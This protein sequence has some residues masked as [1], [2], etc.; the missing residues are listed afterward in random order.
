MN[1]VGRFVFVRSSITKD[2][3]K[4]DGGGVTSAAHS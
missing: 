3:N 1:P 2:V 4:K